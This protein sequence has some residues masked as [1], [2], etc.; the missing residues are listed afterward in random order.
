MHWN[1]VLKIPEQGEPKYN[2]LVFGWLE[3]LGW[4]SL[5]RL[6]ASDYVCEIWELYSFPLFLE[7]ISQLL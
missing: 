7:V 1:S 3:D 4:T 5:S 2:H 6:A